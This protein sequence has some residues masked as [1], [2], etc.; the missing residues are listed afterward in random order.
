MAIPLDPDDRIY[1]TL[2]QTNQTNDG[3]IQL[4]TG[5]YSKLEIE[6]I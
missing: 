6:E 4:R 2:A 1:L 3:H 5:M